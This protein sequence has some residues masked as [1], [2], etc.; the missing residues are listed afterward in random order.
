MFIYFLVGLFT[1]NPQ[2]AVFTQLSSIAQENVP[3]NKIRMI[4]TPS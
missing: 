1:M 3:M 2:M 4:G